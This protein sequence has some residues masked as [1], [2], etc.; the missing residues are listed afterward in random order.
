MARVAVSDLYWSDRQRIRVNWWVILAHLLS[1]G[2]NSSPP[3]VQ[4]PFAAPQPIDHESVDDRTQPS[5]P[6][7]LPLTTKNVVAMNMDFTQGELRTRRTAALLNVQ[8]GESASS[9]LSPQSAPRDFLS[10]R[11]RQHLNIANKMAAR[12]DVSVRA[13]ATG[14]SLSYAEQRHR[15]EQ[16]HTRQDGQDF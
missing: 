3:A 6:V 7:H 4:G 16:A 1:T 9:I 8:F 13:G 15:E 11:H 12:P 5:A 14:Q 10:R 2:T